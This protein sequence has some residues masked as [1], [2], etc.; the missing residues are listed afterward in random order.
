ML[1]NNSKTSSTKHCRPICFYF[2]KGRP[3]LIKRVQSHVQ[4][5]IDKLDPFSHIPNSIPVNVDF[6]FN[7]T[8]TDGAGVNFLTKNSSS[9]SCFICGAKPI[10]MNS[11]NIFD[12]K[13]KQKD[14]YKYRL[15][16]LPEL[17]KIF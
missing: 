6:K 2:Q 5:K 13:V 15:S 9:S 10:D 3:T 17:I 11:I 14:F 7:L 12:R 8:M 4:I 16:T 1:R